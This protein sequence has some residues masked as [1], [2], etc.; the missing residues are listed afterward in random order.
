V[1]GV[2]GPVGALE[3][4][5]F[6]TIG[7]FW[8]SNDSHIEEFIVYVD[9]EYRRSNHAHA[10]MDWMKEQV[11]ITGLPLVTGIISKERTEAKCR[12]YRRMFPKVGEFFL[13]SP[14]GSGVQQLATVAS[15]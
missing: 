7:T 15:S 14:K 2:I 6:V 9:P 11:E 3:A 8:Y 5:V 1:I 13:I 4:L 12:L 10:L